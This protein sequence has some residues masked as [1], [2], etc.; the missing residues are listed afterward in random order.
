MCIVHIRGSVNDVYIVQGTTRL[1][2]SR[3]MKMRQGGGGVVGSREGGR[4][5]G[6]T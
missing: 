1:G 3:T 6:T 5:P 2:P 4:G